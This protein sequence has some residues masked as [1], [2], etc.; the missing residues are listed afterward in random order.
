MLDN[1]L[2]RLDLPLVVVRHSVG[3]V[4]FWLIKSVLGARHIWVLIVW[5]MLVMLLLLLLIHCVGKGRVRVV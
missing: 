1:M 2:I 5:D 3:L 4:M